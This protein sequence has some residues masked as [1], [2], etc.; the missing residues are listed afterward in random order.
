MAKE[1]DRDIK[2]ALAKELC[3]FPNPEMTDCFEELTKG[4]DDNLILTLKNLI[5]YQKK[6]GQNFIS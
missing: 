3:W 1:A 6:K 4:A 2:L 5:E